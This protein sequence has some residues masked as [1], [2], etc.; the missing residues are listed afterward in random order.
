[1]KIGSIWRAKAKAFDQGYIQV[2]RAIAPTRWSKTNNDWL[3][4][5]VEVTFAP[6]GHQWPAPEPIT[7]SLSKFIDMFHEVEVGGAI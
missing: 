5:E 6:I 4:L 1:M 2:L 7:M 3:T